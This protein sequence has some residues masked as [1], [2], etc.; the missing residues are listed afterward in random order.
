MNGEGRER[1]LHDHI[2]DRAAD[3]VNEALGG[4]A[5]PNGR[6]RVGRSALSVAV[7]VADPR[8]TALLLDGGADVNA[9]DPSSGAS[10]LMQ[11]AFGGHLEIVKVLLGAGAEVDRRDNRGA[12]AL[13]CAAEQRQAQAVALLLEAGADP[14]ARTHDG[15][16]P[17]NQG[18]WVVVETHIQGTER[19]TRAVKVSEEDG[20]VRL[21]LNAGAVH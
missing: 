6:D 11:A 18:C 1:S 4:G 8:I 7:M 3:R 14:N 10:P 2:W 15:R 19:W 17:L 5:D 9:Q 16:T 12:T 20:L 13:I 21:L